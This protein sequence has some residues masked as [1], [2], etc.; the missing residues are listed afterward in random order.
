MDKETFGLYAYVFLVTVANIYLWLGVVQGG[1]APR[2][3]KVVGLIVLLAIGAIFS[4][5]FSRNQFAPTFIRAGSLI[6]MTL[7]FFMLY[8][9]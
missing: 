1:S 7:M 4:D 6:G 8:N 3:G 5:K 9:R 2:S